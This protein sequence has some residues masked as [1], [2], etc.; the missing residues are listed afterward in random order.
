MTT[1]TSE[2]RGGRAKARMLRAWLVPL[3]LFAVVVL[4]CVLM[5]SGYASADWMGI[6]V[7]TAAV[8]ASVS[9]MWAA[10]RAG[11]TMGG[12]EMVFDLSDVALS[13]KRPGSADVQVRFD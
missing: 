13:R 9:S 2:A 1:F 11:A 8:A 3:A 6:A 10:G 12:R 5:T 7:S 4:L